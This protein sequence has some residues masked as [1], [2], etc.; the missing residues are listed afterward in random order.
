MFKCCNCLIEYA[1]GMVYRSHRLFTAEY[2]VEGLNLRNSF[3]ERF[4]CGLMV[5]KKRG[6]L[7]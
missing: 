6:Y 5:G 4:L 7:V 3:S 2:G 1:E